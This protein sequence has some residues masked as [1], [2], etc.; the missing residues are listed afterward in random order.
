MF[1]RHPF[2]FLLFFLPPLLLSLFPNCPS[3]LW[4][5]LLVLTREKCRGALDFNPL[6]TIASHLQY[7]GDED[8]AHFLMSQLLS[9]KN[10]ENEKDR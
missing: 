3:S 9:R 1:V 6:S 4:V 2:F 8:V 7:W 5:A 10:G